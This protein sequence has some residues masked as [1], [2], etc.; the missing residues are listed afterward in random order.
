VYRFV[1]ITLLLLTTAVV[2]A[3]PLDCPDGCSNSDNESSTQVSSCCIDICAWCLGVTVTYAAPSLPV[4][5]IVTEVIESVPPL[6]LVGSVTSIEH[7]PRF[8][9]NSRNS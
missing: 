6:P 4:T 8:V 9:F 3:D 7:P 5:R 1:A 2:M